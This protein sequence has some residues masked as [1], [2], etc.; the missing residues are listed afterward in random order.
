MNAIYFISG[1]LDLTVE[2][3]ALY[4]IPLI[5]AA[6]KFNSS[7]V[8]GDARGAD[9]MAQQYLLGKTDNVTV[10]HMF[11]SPRHNVG[12]KT[13]GGYKSDIERDVTMTVNSDSDI[14]WTRPGKEKSGTA[15]NV[16]RR[17]KK[18]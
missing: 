11:D 18:E 10:Y 3:F 7:F 13:M 17:L 2:E 16:K 9:H 1:H 12:F 8:V 14:A 15:K 5:D 4:Y 6:L